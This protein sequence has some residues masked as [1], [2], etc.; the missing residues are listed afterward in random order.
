MTTYRIELSTLD[1][2]KGIRRYLSN[3]PEFLTYLGNIDLLHTT[4]IGLFCS[5]QCPGN[6]ILRLYDW[7][8]DWAKKDWTKSNS[9]IVGGFHSPMEDE[10]LRL[11]LR[12]KA[13]V[14]LCHA[15]SIETLRVPSRFKPALEEGRMLLLSPFSGQERRMTRDLAERRNEFV[16]AL[17]DAILIAHAAPGSKTESFAR[18][19][20]TWGKPLY[21]ID[22]PDNRNSIELGAK[23][24]EQNDSPFE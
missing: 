3:P 15:R 22:V 7:M 16:A 11:L 9:A 17:A 8:N 20:A 1:S 4:C 10:C 6:V 13:G 12:G 5:R 21:T 18:R 2:R 23:S 14:I 19:I 24:I